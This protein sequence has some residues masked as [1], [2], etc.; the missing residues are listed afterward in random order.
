MNGQIPIRIDEMWCDY[1]A[2]GPHKWMFA[3]AGCGILWGRPEML[4]RLW[5]SIVTG[6]GTT[7]TI[8]RRGS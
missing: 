6:V 1:Y 4:E 8:R 2:G 3:P 7:R 5:P